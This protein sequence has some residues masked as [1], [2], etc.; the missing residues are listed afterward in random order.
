MRE[1]WQ[2]QLLETIPSHYRFLFAPLVQ[3][4]VIKEVLSK[5]W[6]VWVG[7]RMDNGFNAASYVAR[8]TKRPPVAESSILGYNG[9][10]VLFTFVEHKTK[11][12]RCLDRT[13]DTILS[14]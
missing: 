11:R 10:R 3:N 12:R 14:F 5:V 8:Y 6:Y 13:S 2:N 4:R 1:L 7:K 9:E